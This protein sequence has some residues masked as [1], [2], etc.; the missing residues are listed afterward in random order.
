VLLIVAA[1][2][3]RELSALRQRATA[4]GLDALVEVHNSDELSVAIDAGASIIGVNNRNLRTLD[5]DVRAS[6]TL[7][8]R[9]PQ[10]VVAVSESGLRTPDDLCRLQSL[11]YRAFL[12]GER[13]MTQPNPGDELKALLAAAR[14]TKDTKDTKART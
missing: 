12:I 6:E 4:L 10:N 1:L 7:I 11:G 8:A 14:N 9:I 2:P 3:P 5:V 13:F